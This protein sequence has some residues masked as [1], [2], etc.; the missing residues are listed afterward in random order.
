MRSRLIFVSA[1]SIIL[2]DIMLLQQTAAMPPCIC[3][4]HLNTGQ[5]Y[6]GCKIRKGKDAGNE[7]ALGCHVDG[8]S[9]GVV[10]IDESWRAISA[11]KDR[12][13]RCEEVRSTEIPIRGDEESDQFKKKDRH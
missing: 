1:L 6:R 7:I 3:L 11:G 8:G 10:V 4:E 2:L 13:G 12:C 9:V 5:I